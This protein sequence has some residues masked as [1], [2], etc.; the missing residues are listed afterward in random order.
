MAKTLVLIVMKK[1]PEL[2]IKRVL[3]KGS[4]ECKNGE[5]Q[6]NILSKMWTKNHLAL[7]ILMTKVMEPQKHA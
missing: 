4:C 5:Q 6:R 7:S 2:L 1:K 3:L